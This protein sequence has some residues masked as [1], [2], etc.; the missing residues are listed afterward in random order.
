MTL[1]ITHS[2]TQA[3]ATMDGVR[4]GELNYHIDHE[5]QPPIW[6]LYS[7]HVDPQAEGQGVGSAL[8]GAVLARVD[9]MDARVVPTCWFV[10]GWLDR[11]PDFQH[12][13]AD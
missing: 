9:E 3:V 7:T 2:P 6:T 1:K 4:V 13:R 12:L 10:A 11:H 8:V 5:R